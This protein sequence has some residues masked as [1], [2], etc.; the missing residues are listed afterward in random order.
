MI[1]YTSGTTGPPKGCMMLHKNYVAVIEALEQVEQFHERG[2]VCLLFLPLAHTYAQLTLYTASRIGFTIAFCADMTRIPEAIGA[3]RPTTMPSV[4]RVYEKVHGAVVAQFDAAT[5]AKRRIV[6]WAVAVGRRASALRREGRNLPPLLAVQHRLAGRLVYSKVKDRLG[7]RLRFG[8]SGAAP[9]SVEILEF[10]A[11]LDIL[12]LEGYGLTESSSGC[13]VNRPSRY[14]FGTVGP[15]LPGV[16]VKIAEDGEI[17]MRGDNVFAGYYKEPDATAEAL[18]QEG[19]L[20]TGDVGELDDGFLRITDR[21]KDLIKT[22]GG[23]YVAPQKV[24]VIFKAVSPYAS[25]IVV[26]GDTRNYV[27]ALITLDPD[28]MA[29]WGEQNGMPGASYEEIVTSIAVRDVIAGHI[30]E[31]NAR[32]ERWE[33]IKRFA[34]LPQDLTV[35]EGDLTPSLKVKRKVVEMKYAD[36][37]DRMYTS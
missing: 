28:A 30:D 36:T 26:H 15:P 29:T 13:S 20:H 1:V 16:E 11:S 17:L 2:E 21:K 9:I 37:L 25:Q 31:L 32:L 10:F 14:R 24:E 3:V 33:T 5:G 4:P 8:I 27:T 23:K 12:I 35:E 7:G 19:W 34:I 22:S 6:D 18:D